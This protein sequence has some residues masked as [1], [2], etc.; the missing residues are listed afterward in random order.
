MSDTSKFRKPHAGDRIG[1]VLGNAIV[2]VIALKVVFLLLGGSRIIELQLAQ[3]AA[4]NDAVAWNPVLFLTPG[5]AIGFGWLRYSL[6]MQGRLRGVSWIG[7]TV[8]GVMIAFANVP[9]AGLLLG[10]LNDNPFRGLLLGLASLL[11]LPSLLVS[12]GAFGA[13][14]GLYNAMKAEKWLIR[15]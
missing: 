15:K 14:M 7:G 12:M 3:W 2:A 5:A 10:I 4:A 13:I 1:M 9:V 6:V 11:L 8:Q